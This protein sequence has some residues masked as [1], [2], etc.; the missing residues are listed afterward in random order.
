MGLEIDIDR[1]KIILMKILDRMESNGSCVFITK[2]DYWDIGPG[3]RYDLTRA[4]GDPVVG[5]LSDDWEFLQTLLNEPDASVPYMFVHLAPLLNA[6]A[7][8]SLPQG[9]E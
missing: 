2:D 3:D 1:L 6:I 4:P 9:S 7:E 8:E 5:K